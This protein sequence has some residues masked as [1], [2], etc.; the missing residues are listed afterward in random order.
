METGVATRILVWHGKQEVGWHGASWSSVLGSTLT[1]MPGQ[2]SDYEG[3]PSA[4]G[5]CALTRRRPI[6]CPAEKT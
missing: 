2:Y 4:I 6:V 3:G 5:V 1:D